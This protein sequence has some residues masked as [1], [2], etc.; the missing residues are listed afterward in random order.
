MAIDKW[1]IRRELSVIAN[2]LASPVTFFT[3]RLQKRSYERTKAQLIRITEGKVPLRADVAIF[4]IYQPKGVADSIFHSCQHLIEKGIS[5]FIVANTPLNDADR[6]RL[7]QVCWRIMERP[8]FGYDFG[9]YREGI[10]HLHAQGL[11]PERLF[12]LNDSI[13]FPLFAES[14]LID[15]LRELEVD[16]ASPILARF[17]HRAGHSF[18]HSYLMRFSRRALLS[19]GFLRYWSDLPMSSNKMAVVRGG[20]KRMAMRMEALGLTT[21]AIWTTEDVAAAL[22]HLPEPEYQAAIRFAAD[23]YQ[24]NRKRLDAAKS[25]TPTMNEDRATLIGSGF[26]GRDVLKAYPGVTIGMMGVPFLKKL[27]QEPFAKARTALLQ[28]DLASALVPV[29]RDELSKWD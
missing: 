3:N 14:D 24:S 29:V 4:L 19:D 11:M 21:G 15:R 20:E 13:W 23:V 25:G 26:F 1:K 27:R 2:Q 17:K 9:G 6:S 12:L 7:A 22:V 8:N 16:V 10:L 18:L 5:P 28:S